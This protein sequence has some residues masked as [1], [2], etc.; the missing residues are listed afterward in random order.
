MGG[1]LMGVMWGWCEG[2]NVRG[3][4]GGLEV[5]VVKRRE[6][7]GWRVLVLYIGCGDRLCKDDTHAGARMG[8]HSTVVRNLLSLYLS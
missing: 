5:G 7:G 6:M 2:G 4:G 3:K 8:V 1:G